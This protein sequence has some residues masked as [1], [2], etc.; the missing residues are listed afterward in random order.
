MNKNYCD[1]L[2]RLLAYRRSM[3]KTQ[4]EMSRQ[5]GITQ[6][7]YS[8]IEA[9]SKIISFQGLQNF[10]KNGGDAFYL[11]TGEHKVNG[12]VEGYLAGCR[13]DQGKTALFKIVVWLLRLGLELG[14]MREDRRI[15]KAYKSLRLAETELEESGVWKNI[16]RLEGIS[17]T[18]M[19][20]RLDINIKRYGRIENEGVKPDAEI[21]NTLY[22]EFGYSP[23]IFFHS[24]LSY[25][26]E[27]NKIWNEFT[28]EV[29]NDLEVVIRDS[30][31]LINKYEKK[32]KS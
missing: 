27:A 20:E 2:E 18:A 9:G 4:E 25:T 1:I 6:G 15:Q 19:A 14:G 17:R 8:K 11:L 23:L 5:F 10:E 24:G 32:W 29:R 26:N 30:V 21:M 3:A 12:P 7:H 13:T 16:R 28:E 31:S 22:V